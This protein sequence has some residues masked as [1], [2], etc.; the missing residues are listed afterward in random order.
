[1]NFKLPQ[2]LLCSWTAMDDVVN[3]LQIPSFNWKLKIVI[4]SYYWSG[5]SF[6]LETSVFSEFNQ[7]KQKCQKHNARKKRFSQSKNNL[8]WRILCRIEKISL[9]F[10]KNTSKYFVISHTARLA[11]LLPSQMII[12]LNSLLFNAA[13]RCRVFCCYGRNFRKLTFIYWAIIAVDI[14]KN[15]IPT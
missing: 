7:L 9:C 10:H 15:S 3:I 2:S 5:D 8:H 4:F 13:L 12:K 11:P 14:E 1:M 6:S